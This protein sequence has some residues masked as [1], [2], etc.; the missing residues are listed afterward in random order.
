[1][2]FTDFQGVTEHAVSSEAVKPVSDSGYLGSG[3]REW[4]KNQTQWAAAEEAAP[5]SG[6]K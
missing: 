2:Q 6:S 5:P 4:P 3:Q 1:M